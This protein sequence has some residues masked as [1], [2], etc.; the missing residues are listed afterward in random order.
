MM[1]RALHRRWMLYV[2]DKME[3][4][5][6]IMMAINTSTTMR[7]AAAVLLA[8]AALLAGC[9]KDDPSEAGPAER[10]GRKVDEV[11]AKAGSELSQ[12]RDTAG[13]Q[14]SEAAKDSGQKIDRAAETAGEKLDRASETAGQKIDSAATTAGQKFN[15]AT[16]AAGRKLEQAGE[17]MQEKAREREAGT[18]PA[19]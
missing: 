14:M 18:T 3:F 4:S 8:M 5:R 6:E 12:V 17:K 16:D 11:T 1:S 15:E 7:G 13:Q 9:Q 10:A 19:K 2:N